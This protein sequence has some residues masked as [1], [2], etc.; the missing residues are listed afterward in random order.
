MTDFTPPDPSIDTLDALSETECRRLLGTQTL[1]RVGMTSG[2]LP[3]ILPVCYVYDEGVVMFRT[4]VGTKLRAAESGDVLA[5]EVD[6]YDPEMGQGW[7]VLVLGRASVVTTEQEHEG[8]PTLDGQ[9][10]AG[11]RNHYVR[12]H[13]EM[14]TGRVIEPA[15]RI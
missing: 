6:N 10:E 1:G 15:H 11:E 4:G 13:C 9:R 12:L 3:C 14:V 5:F 8:L 7:S 2:G